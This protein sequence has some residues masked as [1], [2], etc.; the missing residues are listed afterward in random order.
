MVGN[1]VIVDG[2]LELNGGDIGTEDQPVI[3][4]VD[5]SLDV[6]GSPIINGIVFVRGEMLHSAGT[7]EFNGSLIVSDDFS[8]VGNLTVTYNSEVNDNA[9]KLGPAIY[10]PG[11]WRDW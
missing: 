9:S 2:D 10:M 1:I 7:P 11:A 4:I 8:S 5:G 3:L 6:K